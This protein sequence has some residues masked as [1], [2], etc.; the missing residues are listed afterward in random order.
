VL[1][2]ATCVFI[3]SVLCVNVEAVC[4]AGKAGQACDKCKFFDLTLP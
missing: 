3:F 2:Y 4:P 1:N